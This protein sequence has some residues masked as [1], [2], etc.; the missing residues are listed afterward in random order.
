[1]AAF[2]R[3]VVESPLAGKNTQ[4]ERDVKGNI[5]YSIEC[6][7]DSLE[8]GEAPFAGHILY[9]TTGVLDDTNAYERMLGVDAHLSW[10]TRSDAV[11]VYTD[12]GISTGM[13][14]GIRC[15]ERHGVPIVYRSLGHI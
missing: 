5:A 10:L 13:L 9:A 8:R 1:M 11:I 15:A 6:L 7:R 14:A 2:R 3:V 4:Y 12:R